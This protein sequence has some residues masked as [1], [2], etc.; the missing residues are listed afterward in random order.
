M[1]LTYD[2]SKEHSGVD[3]FMV[4]YIVLWQMGAICLPSFHCCRLPM[5]SV[6][7]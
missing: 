4:P 1:I 7:F 3:W 6:T 5:L 2:F